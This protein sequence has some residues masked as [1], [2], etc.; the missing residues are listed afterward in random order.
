MPTLT[1]LEARLLAVERELHDQLA[2]HLPAIATP[3]VED[4]GGS[5]GSGSGE[6]G[7]GG[8]GSAGAEDAASGAQGGAEDAGSGGGFGGEDGGSVAFDGSVDGASPSYLFIDPVTGKVYLVFSGSI[9]LPESTGSSPILGS[10][11][12]WT[13]DGTPTG[14]LEEYLQGYSTGGNHSLTLGSLQAAMQLL[15]NGAGTYGLIQILVAGTSALNIIDSNFLSH[16][17]QA[18]A[19]GTDP[20]AQFLSLPATAYRAA[21]QTL[22]A[23]VVKVSLDTLDDDPGAYFTLPDYVCKR[24]GRFLVCGQV[25]MTSTA[26]GQSVTARIIKN[27]TITNPNYTGSADISSAAAQTLISTVARVINCASGDTISLYASSPGLAL[28]VGAASGS[29]WLSVL[30][31]S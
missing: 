6:D 14:T 28:A 1:E 4:S 19:H 26:A 25:S 23:G 18:D 20:R 24:A 8:S 2:R 16:F 3:G 27:S 30:E 12:G 11:V 21:A 17:I 9:I 13:N 10:Y 22:A 7:G 15:T 29:N 5:G 31:V